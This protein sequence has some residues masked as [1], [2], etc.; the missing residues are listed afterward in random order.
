LTELDLDTPAPHESAYWPLAT[1][2]FEGDCLLASAPALH[3][4]FGSM[5]S[6]T[7]STGPSTFA[8]R[9]RQASRSWWPSS[10][11]VSDTGPALSGLLTLSVV[12]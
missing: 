11:P 6:G 4:R 2:L 12:V 3:D 1:R 8:A 7:P 9:S 5:S 10:A